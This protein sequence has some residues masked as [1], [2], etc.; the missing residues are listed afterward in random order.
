MPGSI[1]A[2]DGTKAWDGFHRQVVTH[3]HNELFESPIL[4]HKRG[5]DRQQVL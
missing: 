3:S 5:L 1:P 4:T 2:S